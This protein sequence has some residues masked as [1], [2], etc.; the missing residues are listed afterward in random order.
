MLPF[1]SFRKFWPRSWSIRTLLLALTAS[2]LI[3]ALA[4]SLWALHRAENRYLTWMNE[5]A[6]QIAH[7][8][9]S[10]LDREM[11]RV[12]TEIDGLIRSPHLAADDYSEFLAAAELAAKRLG[13]GRIVLLNSRLQPILDTATTAADAVPAADPTTAKKALDS[14]EIAFTGLLSDPGDGRWNTQVH[15]PFRV[16]NASKYV[17]VAS[18]GEQAYQLVLQ[19]QHL[20]SGW[21]RTVVDASG[22]IVI[23][24]NGSVKTASLPRTDDQKS[25]DPGRGHTGQIWP[26]DPVRASAKSAL[27]NWSVHVA[28]ENAP[29]VR[30]SEVGQLWTFLWLVVPLILTAV[31]ILIFS[32]MMEA[33]I[34]TAVGAVTLMGR[35]N[36]SPHLETNLSEMKIVTGALMGAGEEIQKR[37]RALKEARDEARWRAAE[38]EEA[39]ALLHTLLEHVPDGITI[40]LGA[41]DFPIVASSRVATELMQHPENSLIGMPISHSSMTFG[42]VRPDGTR[43]ISEEMPLYR[44]CH[45]GEKIMGEE[46]ILSRPD[47]DD[48]VCLVNVMP[49]R[50]LAGDIIGAVN[51]LRD[52]TARKREETR[53]RQTIALSKAISDAIPALMYVKDLD[54]RLTMVNQALLRTL[55]QT[56]AQ[57]IGKTHFELFGDASQSREIAANDRAVL[58]SGMTLEVEETVLRADGVHHY[59]S[60]KSPIFGDDGRPSAVV[61]VSVDITD[62]KR[63]EAAARLLSEIE[64]DSIALADPHEMINRAVERLGKHLSASRCNLAIIDPKH[65]KL[66]V[67]PG[68][69]NGAASV[70][71]SYPLEENTTPEL[72]AAF[73]R[74]QPFAV[75][76]VAHDKRTTAV[77]ERYLT[78][79]VAAFAATPILVGGE[80]R[81]VLG[82]H[83]AA[84]R[85]WLPDELS[86]LR[87]VGTRVWIARERGIAQAALRTSEE[88][89]RLA[90]LA[91]EGMIYD[92]DVGLGHVERSQGLA[93]L[94][95]FAPE[96][97]HPKIDWWRER[98]HPDDLRRIDQER[99]AALSERRSNLQCHYRIR[100]RDGYW[101]HVMDRALVL[102]G[103][104]GNPR[105]WVG[106]IVDVTAQDHAE[107]RLR[108]T[109]ERFRALVQAS[110]QTVWT[111]NSMGE[112][113]ED[114]PSWRA[115]TGQT[116]MQFLGWGWLDAVHPQDRAAAADAMRQAIASKVPAT[117][118]YRLRHNSGEWRWTQARTVPLINEDRSIRSWLG[119]N[120]DITDRR[121]WEEQQKLLLGELSHRVKN[122]L[123]VVQSMAT[124]TLTGGRSLA[125]AGEVLIRRLHALSRAHDMLT[126]RN[127]RGAPLRA[128]VDSELAP[129]AGRT[130][131]DGPELMIGPRMAQT[132]AL[133]LHELA[134]NATK[135]GALS[136]DEGQVSVAWSVL[137]TGEGARF[138][139]EWRET[140]GPPVV[141]P[142]RKGFGTSLLNIAIAGDAEGISPLRFEP[143]GVIYEINVPLSSV[144]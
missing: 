81:A 28:A 4:A 5:R 51:C 63:S 84:P 76:D 143:G 8:L 12:V 119:M 104:D 99:N 2:V 34:K 142:E 132:L 103:E 21:L 31:S 97:A 78:G 7:D 59:I 122:V 87:E 50:N 47:G 101:V 65:D 121:N 9:S 35:G 71:G 25:E 112:I 22:R 118:E 126:T 40:A 57:V 32:Q 45:H 134:T 73:A 120:T 109:E 52:I 18:P 61:G 23:Q 53:M 125:E 88:R 42:A 129:F 14:N 62:R 85:R 80:L 69:V 46:L 108:E 70:A 100:H 98:C 58:E 74:G 56:E 141:P 15:V 55:N 41:P 137:G 82:V 86:L 60:T 17:L 43:P 140:G 94:I 72:R 105:R 64:H 113:V 107:A 77:A 3:P 68:W 89:Y 27:T 138:L 133:V 106:S 75:D 67:E 139:F 127:W 48:I 115:F 49:L 36:R 19:E 111:T 44:A 130:R 92:A 11:K 79:G 30:S 6:E 24:G 26:N 16:K 37:K 131:V 136:N 93:A 135:H 123:A 128:I 144:A 54:G 83:S 38:A 10:D 13:D 29:P 124:R 95:G 96:E 33:P 39:R 90:A 91:V 114:S 20:P 116:V 102:Y 117:M 66:T 1:K 110:A